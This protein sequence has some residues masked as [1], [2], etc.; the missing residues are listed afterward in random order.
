[1]ATK[2]NARSGFYFFHRPQLD[3]PSTKHAPR[4]APIPVLAGSASIGVEMAIHPDDE[5]YQFAFQRLGSVSLARRQYARQGLRI[6]TTFGRIA[7][8]CF[9]G[10]HA[11]TVL[12]FASGHGRATR[13]LA[14]HL[15]AER[16]WASDIKDDAVSFCQSTIGVG[17][18]T[19]TARPE[20][21][22]VV[23]RF[24]LIVVSSLFSH[25]PRHLFHGWLARLAALLE[26]GGVLAFSVHGSEMVD[27]SLMPADGYLFVAESESRVLNADLYGT[28][29]VT[30]GFV[31]GA[32]Q[33]AFGSAI[34]MRCLPKGLCGAQDLYVV[35]RDPARRVEALPLLAEPVGYVDVC[36][37]TPGGHLHVT[38]WAGTHD[39][40]DQLQWVTL[41]LDGV[42]I[43]SSSAQLHRPDVSAVLGNPALERS[44]FDVRIGIHPPFT[45]DRL[46]EA[47]ART[48]RGAEDV[49]LASSL[50]DL[51]EG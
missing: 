38:G 15:G 1:M 30:T 13:F 28:A 23:P 9:P 40:G 37:L 46:L 39:P 29:Y 18:F 21:L 35:S 24:D 34:H 48:L 4:G 6:A 50:A 14:A 19:S 16:V 3:N 26:P 41:E 33:A 12:D 11:P 25:L 31:T 42:R 22:E 8:W 27:P 7:E 5:M 20:D 17:G 32:V 36:V 49:L 43:A 44:G 45:G 51:L 2:K 10:A 47:K